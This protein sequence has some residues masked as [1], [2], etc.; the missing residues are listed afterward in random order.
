MIGSMIRAAN[1]RSARHAFRSSSNSTCS[2]VERR[3][4]AQ[5]RKR[6][7]CT[8]CPIYLDRPIQS[9]SAIR[10]K[11]VQHFTAVL[12]CRAAPGL[13]PPG[14]PRCARGHCGICFPSLALV[15][16]IALHH[17]TLPLRKVPLHALFLPA[18]VPPGNLTMATMARPGRGRIAIAPAPRPPQAGAS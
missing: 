11:T 9:S 12:S 4:I 2:R 5:P 7:W 8:N 1:R 14:P 3:F 18:P 16:S 17:T 10:A 6:I 15:D 13:A